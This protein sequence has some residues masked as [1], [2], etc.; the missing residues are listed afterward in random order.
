MARPRHYRKGPRPIRSRRR[1]QPCD[2][3]AQY[4]ENRSREEARALA[5]NEAAFV[6]LREQT[7]AVAPRRADR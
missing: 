3:A 7:E 4:L 2:S 6:R 5:V 1:A